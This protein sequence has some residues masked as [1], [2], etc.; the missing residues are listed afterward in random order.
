MLLDLR[1]QVLSEGAEQGLTDVAVDRARNAM[2]LALTDL[3]GDLEIRAYTL[4][5]DG[6]PIDSPRLVLRLEQPHEW[7]QGGDIEVGPDGMVYISFGDG[8]AIG[9]PGLN[10]QDPATLLSSIIRIDPTRDGYGV[11]PGNPFVG[12]FFTPGREEVIAYG[13]RNPWRMSFDRATDA[14][15]IGDVGQNCTEEVNVLTSDEW[16]A[17]FGWSGLEGSYRF[18]GDVP[19]DH[20]LPVFEYAHRSAG[21]AITGGYVY[22]GTAIPELRGMYVFADYC[23]GQLHA[24]ELEGNAVV[25]VVDLGVRVPLLPSFGERSDGEL[26]VV[27]LER[28]PALLVPDL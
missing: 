28:G 15:W 22:R 9:D 10:G 19:A 14:L 6:L 17:N 23:R 3:R 13:L 27:S 2:Y 4:D 20:V 26:L 16:G 25:G 8:G 1:D 21:C 11:P 5:P 18:Q 12:G 7:H 24:L